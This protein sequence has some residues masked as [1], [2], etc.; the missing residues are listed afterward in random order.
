MESYLDFRKNLLEKGYSKETIYKYMSCL[1]RYAAYMGCNELAGKKTM[2]DLRGK[3]FGYLTVLEITGKHNRS[4]VVWRCICRCGNVCEAPS[5]LLLN[6]FKKNCGCLRAANMQRINQYI[7]GTSIRSSLDD[8]VISE[9]SQSGYV[10]VSPKRGKWRA[11]VRFKGVDHN[12]GTYEDLGDAV[13]ARMH[14]RNR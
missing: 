13:K 8:K 14:I 3:Q 5:S 1:N 9:E 10:G 4:D 7:D 2:A 12:L 6:G 11:V